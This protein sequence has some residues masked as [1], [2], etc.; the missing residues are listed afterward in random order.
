ML[1]RLRSAAPQ[2]ELHQGEITAIALD[3]FLAEY[4]C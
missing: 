4:G 1:E 3:R 2:L